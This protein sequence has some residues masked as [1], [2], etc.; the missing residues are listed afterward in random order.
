M[1]DGGLK[2][3][4]INRLIIKIDFFREKSFEYF[5]RELLENSLI[6]FG[7]ISLWF[8]FIWN[9]WRNCLGNFRGGL[10]ISLIE[11]LLIITLNTYVGQLPVWIVKGKKCSV[12][13][14]KFQGWAENLTNK[15]VEN[16][17]AEICHELQDKS[18]DWF[19]ELIEHFFVELAGCIVK[20]KELLAQS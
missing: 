12:L 15:A 18:F 8:I 10:K 14:S 13:A 3:F 17:I 1:E 11:L 16:K 5:L 6:V 19:G 7:I 9:S 4:L 20:G 2:V